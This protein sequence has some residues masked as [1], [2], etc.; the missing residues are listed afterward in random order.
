MKQPNPKQF[1]RTIEQL[2]KERFNSFVSLAARH[3]YNRDHAVD[4]VHS[5]LARSIEYFNKHPER[6]ARE[7]LVNWLILKECKKKN[8]ESKEVPRDNA[9][10]VE[11]ENAG[12]IEHC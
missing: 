7:Q 4:V 5:A 10:F 12:T 3:V 2:Y 6:N 9:W 11:A 1:F 8:R